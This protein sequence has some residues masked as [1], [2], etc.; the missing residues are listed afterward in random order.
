MVVWFTGNSG[1]G[2]STL[3][4]AIQRKIP[5]AIILDGDEMRASISLGAGFSKE[6]R[7]EHNLRVA[8]LAKVLNDQN[9]LI[10]VSVIAPFQEA[11]DKITKIC[12]PIWIYLKRTLPKDKERPYEEPKGVFT[13]NNDWHNDLSNEERI[14]LAS[15]M[16]LK[17][18][19]RK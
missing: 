19:L 5:N 7:E 8:R 17:H 2:K 18:I 12:D 11:R 3:A 4:R 15:Y 9:H 13:I 10:L 16:V 14:D 1:A 6:E